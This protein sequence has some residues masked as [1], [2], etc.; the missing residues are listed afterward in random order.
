MPVSQAAFSSASVSS[1]LPTPRFA[2]SNTFGDI[3]EQAPAAAR[4]VAPSSLTKPVEILSKARPIYTPEARNLGI[5][6][7]VLVEVV[8]EADGKVRV[9]RLVKGLGHGLD[10]NALQAA[11]Q[12]QFRP[13][14]RDGIAS[15]TTAVVHLL[16]QLAE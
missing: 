13:A 1:P 14:S 12:I 15:D 10:E 8:F 9:V 2:A 7:E 6:G 16:F 11:R 4:A 5:Q 3:S